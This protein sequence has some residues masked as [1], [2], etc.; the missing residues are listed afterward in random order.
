MRARTS[1]LLLLVLCGL[2]S[3]SARASEPEV[4][5]LT[6]SV[7]GHS[8]SAL[9]MRPAPAS[10]LLVLAHGAAMNMR[11]PF[12]ESLG[13]AL[14]RRGIATLRFNFPYAEAGRSQPDTPKLL[15]ATLKLAVA[16]GARRRGTLPLLVAG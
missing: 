11:D 8:C 2:L 1:N 9:L 13:A 4:T 16:E 12:M 14:A 15:L 10:A 6:L 3:A 5:N 7:E